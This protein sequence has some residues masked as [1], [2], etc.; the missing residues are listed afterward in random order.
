MRKAIKVAMYVV[1]MIMSIPQRQER[2]AKTLVVLLGMKPPEM[3]KRRVMN[4]TLGN[5]V[6]NKLICTP[7]STFLA[8]DSQTSTQLTE[9][10]KY[11]QFVV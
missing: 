8:G 10:S 6:K 5:I 7:G 2:K 1:R 3:V 4:E 9:V 11:I